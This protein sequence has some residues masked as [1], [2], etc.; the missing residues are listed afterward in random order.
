MNFPTFTPESICEVD[1]K[2]EL[3]GSVSSEDYLGQNW[4][5]DRWIGY[6]GLE[7]EPPIEGRWFPENGIWRFV[8]ENPKSLDFQM[9]KPLQLYDGYWGERVYIVLAKLTWAEEQF[10][11]KKEWDHDHCGIC[12]A[13]IAPAAPKYFRSS[14]QDIVCPNCYKNYVL[15]CSLSFIE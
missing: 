14:E 12:W 5:G 11:V 8:S 10:V 6:I 7:G 2:T 13:T 9:G 15:L 1:H 3:I 4:I